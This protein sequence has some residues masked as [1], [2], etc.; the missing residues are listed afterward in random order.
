M[1]IGA[2][3]FLY[4]KKYQVMNKADRERER[5]RERER[6]DSVVL[7]AT[8]LNVPSAQHGVQPGLIF[9][10]GERVCVIIPFET[11]HKD[12]ARLFTLVRC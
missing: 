8:R 12:D 9:C 4:H 7:N 6:A 5:E 10:P 11:A 2:S 3:H 1:L